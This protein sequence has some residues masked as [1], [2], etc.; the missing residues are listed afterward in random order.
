MSYERAYAERTPFED[1]KGSDSPWPEFPSTSVSSVEI[2]K[3][4]GGTP[5]LATI[6][7]TRFP[8]DNN[9]AIHGGTGTDQSNPA[10]LEIWRIQ[11]IIEYKIGDRDYGKARTVVRAQ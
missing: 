5:V 2:G 1:L 8:D 9:L 11:S 10:G 3:L 4:P 6:T 7:R